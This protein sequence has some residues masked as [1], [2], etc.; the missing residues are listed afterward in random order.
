MFIKNDYYIFET[1]NELLHVGKLG[2]DKG[3]GLYFQ[4]S[5]GKVKASSTNCISLKDLIGVE[6]IKNDIIGEIQN[7][8]IEN[9]YIGI[10]WKSVNKEFSHYFWNNINELQ[11]KTPLKLLPITI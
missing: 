10:Y 5:Y 2:F 3:F 1:F 11:W 4:A 6:I 7:Y 8:S 9:K